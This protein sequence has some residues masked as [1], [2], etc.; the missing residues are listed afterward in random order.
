MLNK[1]DFVAMIAE[2]ANVTKKA[3]LE[4]TDMVI[5]GIKKAFVEHG[6]VQ[7]VNFGTFCVSERGGRPGN[8]MN[9]GKEVKQVWIEKYLA[10]IFRPS[11]KIREMLN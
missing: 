7:F 2:D 3:A 10:P 8:D 5:N 6:G 1:Q 9:S 11:E 4:A